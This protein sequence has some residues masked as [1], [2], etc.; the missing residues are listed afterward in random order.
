MRELGSK[1]GLLALLLHLLFDFG[2]HR[3]LPDQRLEK[4]QLRD[5]AAIEE[6]CSEQAGRNRLLRNR[7]YARLARD[8]LITRKGRALDR[9]SLRKT[10]IWRYARR[11]LSTRASAE[12]VHRRSLPFLFLLLSRRRGRHC[13]RRIG[14][15]AR[16]KRTRSA[17]V[18]TCYSVHHTAEITPRRADPRGSFFI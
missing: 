13:S 7:R 4:L 9:H 2:N 5:I 8:T 16:R 11:S 15:T 17:G 3:Q 12:V 14:A 6:L 18:N 1:E 10:R